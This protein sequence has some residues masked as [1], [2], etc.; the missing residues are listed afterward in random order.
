MKDHC[1][2]KAMSSQCCCLQSMLSLS[3]WLLLSLSLPCC[4]SSCSCA[5]YSIFFSF[6]SLLLLANSVYWCLLRSLACDRGFFVHLFGLCAC[7]SSWLLACLLAW[8]ICYS[9]FI[10]LLSLVVGCCWFVLLCCRCPCCY[11][12][13]LFAFVCSYIARCARRLDIC[14]A[15]FLAGLLLIK[16]LVTVVSRFCYMPALE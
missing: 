4:C 2:Q 5:W 13:C 10:C 11:R 9:L 16:W 7:F 6:L 14:M 8:L 1:S 3:W 15:G 12:R